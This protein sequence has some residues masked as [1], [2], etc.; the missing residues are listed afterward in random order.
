MRTWTK[1]SPPRPPPKRGPS[2]PSAAAAVEELVR[3]LLGQL[4]DWHQSIGELVRTLTTATE[5]R[6]L[7]GC[8]TDAGRTEN[9][10]G[11]RPRTMLLKA[12]ARHHHAH[13]LA[14]I[15]ELGG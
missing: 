7:P 15:V 6:P 3:D 1:T 2:T 9:T 4:A 8:S 12:V 13:L 10:G 14:A 5:G 11:A